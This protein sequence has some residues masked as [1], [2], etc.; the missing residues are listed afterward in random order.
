M[1]RLHP[2][3]RRL[4]SI[5][6]KLAVIVVIAVATAVTGA[7]I[8]QGWQ[9]AD[10]QY[11]SL[12]SELDAVAATIA[13]AVAPAQSRGDY[14]DVM[15]TLRAIG[16]M[17]RVT[18]AHIIDSNG[19][20]I[21]QFGNGVMLEADAAKAQDREIGLVE[22][23]ALKTLPVEAA[24]IEGGREIARLMLIADV[25]E[26]RGVLAWSL[27]TSLAIGMVAAACAI[28]L[29]MRLEAAVTG[30]IV[31]LIQAMR[32]VREN[33]D[34]DASVARQ[35]R[36]ETGE[37]VDAFNDMLREIRLRDLALARH[38]DTLEA[39]VEARTRELRS[40]SEAAQ[41]ANAAKS[42]FLATMSHEIRTP[43][44]GMLVMAELLTAGGLSP[45]LQRYA[46]VIVSSGRSLLAI[47]N[48]ILDLSK[49]EAGKLEL[50]A[51]PV[52]PRKLV[53]DVV[54]LFAERA[55]SRGL[56]IAGFVEAD[57]PEDIVADPVRVTQ[58]LS[59][60][61]NNALKFTETGGVSVRVAC[62]GRGAE[63]GAET[64]GTR[65]VFTVT[66]TGIGIPRDRLGAIFDAFSQADQSTTRRF[67]G[68]GIG[69]AICQRLADAMHGRITVESVP[70]S[71]STFAL[72]APFPVHTPAARARGTAPSPAGGFSVLV[73][74]EPGQTRD[75]LLSHL[76][77]HGV[78]ARL[79]GAPA[80][81]GTA[82]DPS[83]VIG[84]APWPGL[85]EPARLLARIG[86]GELGSVS[87]AEANCIA[88]I[89]WPLAH[90]EV[91]A[92]CAAIRSGDLSRLA[93]RLGGAREVA[94]RQRFD[95]VR[96]LAADDSAIN[97]E[98]LCEALGTLGVTVETV[99]NGRAAVAAVSAR[100]FDLVFMDGS[101]PEVDGYEAT[102]AIRAREAQLGLE[103]LPVIALT[104]HV[105]GSKADRW[106]EVGMD[107][108]VTKPFTIEQ[109]EGAL[110]AF[111]TDRAKAAAGLTSGHAGLNG[112][113]TPADNGPDAGRDDAAV[114]R[115][116]TSRHRTPVGR[117]L[118]DETVLDDIR[119]MQ[120]D[121]SPDLVARVIDLY[122]THAPE[123]LVQLR[124]GW[125]KGADDRRIAELAH[126]LK[127]L[128]RNIGAVAVAEAADEIETAAREERLVR[129]QDRL[130]ALEDA[131]RAT[132]QRLDSNP[133]RA[134]A[135]A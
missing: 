74:M 57:V 88:E 20:L 123:A 80:G 2:H 49:I 92:V 75:A 52:K 58:V 56:D 131:L 9:N 12:A 18:Y 71:G 81:P 42:E 124:E 115:V 106:R 117:D 100:P 109:I 50:E 25:S 32:A 10:R 86:I 62:A 87:S 38:R 3:I 130:D 64:T 69:L 35:S 84:R 118:I 40:A 105:V 68:T 39:T 21:A 102:Q 61:V 91:S 125:A 13:T 89:G 60:L 5:R 45:R 55:Q 94:V 76:A 128:S 93:T 33:H 41:K 63:L 120:T 43:M 83:V 133:T 28:L 51:I 119:Q 4:R 47:I 14:S 77:A 114:A 95:G 90:D 110:A 46:E 23:L 16:R 122:R 72:T 129:A 107:G 31:A 104:A 54:R 26:L 44:N 96:V 112:A 134:A 67:G 11:R 59:N 113:A 82:S 127:S 98:V 24:I 126:A 103:R 8:V 111:L 97:R 116:A 22:L 7:A 135:I 19:L 36:D 99:G 17:P 101:M 48:D 15:K 132:L 73:A 78:P 70:G 29:A 85:P 121:G 37:L 53:D 79:A 66:D 27:A 1:L 30:P 65:L 108:C 34:Y 6:S